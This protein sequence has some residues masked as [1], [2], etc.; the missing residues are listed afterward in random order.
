MEEGG[1]SRHGT[2]S[3]TRVAFLG[4]VIPSFFSLREWTCVVLQSGI[5]WPDESSSPAHFSWVTLGIVHPRR[6]LWI[7]Q[8]VFVLAPY[9]SRVTIST[10]PK[11]P[12]RLV[13]LPSRSLRCWRLKASKRATLGH[14]EQ[15]HSPG[16][17]E[18][19]A[20]GQPRCPSDVGTVECLH[21]CPKC[22]LCLFCFSPLLGPWGL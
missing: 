16:A 6:N 3:P 18:R 2:T 5:A 4:I 19:K 14:R 13:T 15:S 8:A 17:R 9:V 22:P 21:A 7:K 12:P 11:D 10:S 20:L 1:A